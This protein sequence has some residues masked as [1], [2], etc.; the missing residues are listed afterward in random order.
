[1]GGSLAAML[2]VLALVILISGSLSDKAQAA[3]EGPINTQ[4]AEVLLLLSAVHEITSYN[5]NADTRSQHLAAWALLWA[6]DAT[7]VINN[8]V[9]ITGR[10]AIM[11]FFAGAPFFNNNWVGLTPSFRTEIDIHGNTAAVYLECIYLD[12][13]K[14]VVSER[15]LSGVLKKVNG[16]WRF[17]HMRTDPAMALF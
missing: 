2:A 13:S 12:Q 7:F 16:N 8:T 17:W 4:A 3:V 1:M 10:D 9:T 6:E 11:A 5:G 14:I 15:S